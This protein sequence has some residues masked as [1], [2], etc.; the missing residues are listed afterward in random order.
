MRLGVL[1]FSD[2]C[3]ARVRES[4]RCYIYPD[5]PSDLPMESLFVTSLTGLFMTNH[6][7]KFGQWKS[8]LGAPPPAVFVS[9]LF[10]NP[11]THGPVGRRDGF[12]GGYHRCR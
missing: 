8:S 2:V 7:V 3:T 6:K 5:L 9:R 4:T 11:A 12:F 10:M 1:G